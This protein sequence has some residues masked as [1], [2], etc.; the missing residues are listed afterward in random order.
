MFLCEFTHGEHSGFPCAA[1]GRRLP[2]VA[3]AEA[4]RVRREPRLRAGCRLQAAAHML[5]ATRSAM[6]T[7]VPRVATLQLGH[8]TGGKATKLFS[9]WLHYFMIPPAYMQILVTSHPCQYLFLSIFTITAILRG[10]KCYPIMVFIYISLMVNILQHL[11]MD[12]LIISEKLI[13]LKN[14]CSNH[15]STFKFELYIFFFSF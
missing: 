12:F 9:K 1:S 4:S 6:F 5:R 8:Q 13:T 10:L 2:A 3:R 15:W 7:G 14:F 11:F